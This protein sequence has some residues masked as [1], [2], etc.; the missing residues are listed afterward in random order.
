MNNN[1]LKLDA[2]DLVRR[3]VATALSNTPEKEWRSLLPEYTV[4][5][6]L[7]FPGKNTRELTT[8][9]TKQHGKRRVYSDTSLYTSNAL[10]LFY[11]SKRDMIRLA[12]KMPGNII[13][14]FSNRWCLSIS[15][16]IVICKTFGEFINGVICVE[17]V[18]ARRNHPISGVTG[19]EWTFGP[20]ID[21]LIK[22]S[23]H[24]KERRELICKIER[25]R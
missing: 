2:Y 1:P 10:H 14:M 8:L 12:D 19:V 5:L 11:I 15:K 21:K 20:Y 3:A 24:G 23:T 18:G 6:P 7:G 9:S 4:T 17:A 13:E 22:N 25:R 16:P